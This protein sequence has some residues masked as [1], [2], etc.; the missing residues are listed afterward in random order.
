VTC[1]GGG[2]YSPGMLACLTNPT[3][4]RS[5]LSFL[6][7]AAAVSTIDHLIYVSECRLVCLSR[8]KSR[9]IQSFIPRLSLS[10]TLHSTDLDFN[11][12]LDLDINCDVNIVQSFIPG[13]DQPLRHVRI[14]P[15]SCPAFLSCPQ[16]SGKGKTV[17]DRTKDRTADKQEVAYELSICT[18]V[19][20]LG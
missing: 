5:R 15:V 3:R 14:L 19:I 16:S 11:L 7:P 10:L 4:Q 6:R 1:L 20:D 17:H 9:I 2:L 12:D 18:K 13:R 8:H